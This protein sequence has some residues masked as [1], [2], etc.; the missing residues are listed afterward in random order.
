MTDLKSWFPGWA[1]MSFILPHMMSVGCRKVKP[2]ESFIISLL[3][4]GGTMLR[5]RQCQPRSLLERL[6]LVQLSE[7]PWLRVRQCQP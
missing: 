2:V 1:K 3:V 6:L 7:A 5:V 4:V